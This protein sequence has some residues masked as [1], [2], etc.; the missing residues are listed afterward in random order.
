MTAPALLALAVVLAAPPRLHVT[1]APAAARPGDAVLV[2]VSGAA[3]E[4]RGEL[5][6][7]PLAFFRAGREW[8]A[9]AALPT[10]TPVGQVRAT[11]EAGRARAEGVVAIVEPGWPAR[12]IGGVPAKFVNPPPDV[13]ARIAADR[14]AFDEA[15]ARPPEPPRFRRAFAWPRRARVTG[16]FGDQRVFNG[17]KQ[18]VHY[19]T[20]VRGP[21][22][23]PIRAANDGRVVLVR[24][25]YLSGRTVVLSHGAGVFTAYFHLSRIDVRAGQTVRRGAQIGRL[26][27]T[28]RAS[29]PHLH[30]S[31]RVGG[32]FVDP[33]SLLAIDPARG[34]A[35]PRAPRLPP[36]APPAPTV[37]GAGQPAPAPAAGALEAPPQGGDAG[38]ASLSAP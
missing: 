38:P 31:A 1:T 17:V 33:E 25:A 6:G 20:D 18:S 5:A 30:W 28:G 37:A 21:V 13:T 10:E 26:G 3:A 23:A 16:R 9:F 2:R 19:G 24:E 15:Y 27:A 14:A 29:G 8:R 7:R 4:P 11:V 12:A 32:L 35:P 36:A 22:G 34:K